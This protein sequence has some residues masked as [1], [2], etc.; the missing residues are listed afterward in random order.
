MPSAPRPL[1]VRFSLRSA[2]AIVFALAATVLALE[3]LESS[4]RVI[5]W[6]LS[7]AAVA[8]L[9]YPIVGYL[10][11]FIP[12]GLAVLIVF[13]VVVGGVGLAVYGVV[14]DV[15][16]ETKRLQVAAPER[17]AELERNSDL[18]QELKLRRRVER[19]VDEIPQRLQ[20]GSAAEALRSAANRGLAFLA[21]LIL[22][23]FFVIYGRKIVQGSIEQIRD[24]AQRRRVERIVHRASRRAL[25]YAR[26]TLLVSVLEGVI[27]WAVAT[28]ADV[29]GPAALA[30][31]V[32][33]WSL[34]P[35]GGVLIGA[36][37]IVVFAGATSV[38][39]AVVVA[40]VFIAMAAVEH[41]FVKPRLE[42]ATMQLGSFV[43]VVV[44]FAGLELYGFSGALLALLGA[45]LFV[46]TLQELGPEELVEVV[47]APVG[48]VG[49]PLAE[50]EQG[51][52]V[53]RQRRSW[54]D[55]EDRG[56]GG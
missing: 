6:A 48:D 46:A 26:G 36:I 37:P 19:L 7:A 21:S 30:V 28:A 31:W 38:T 8:A 34:V 44:G 17:A 43:T 51:L 5:A 35:V 54:S 24:P 47:K 42:S 9:V 29:P 3:T 27:A 15:Q 1:A 2:F 39:R 11:R 49:E 45:A 20:G 56:T 33:L 53:R 23:L 13:V 55:A 32:A 12:R 18:F 16:R 14:D 52:D 41:V 10:D 40:L 22:A 50:H 25:G 4:E